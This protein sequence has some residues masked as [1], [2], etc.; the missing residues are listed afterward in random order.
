ME[1]VAGENLDNRLEHLARALPE[2]EVLSIASQMAQLLIYLHGQN[3]PI[4]HRDIKPANIIIR[5]E[6]GAVL[7]DFGAARQAIETKSRAIT[8]IVTEG[9][10]PLEQYDASGNQGPWTDIYALGAVAYACLTG[11]KPAS[12][13]SRV[14]NDSLVPLAI[15]AKHPA[16]KNFAGAIESALSVYENERPQSIAEFIALICGALSLPATSSHADDATRVLNADA[17]R[18]MR[19]VSPT[20]SAPAPQ[21]APIPHSALALQSAPTPQSTKRINPAFLGAA[22]AALLV[23][24]VGGWFA[25]RGVTG[26]QIAVKEPDSSYAPA[27]QLT[28]P[29]P[30]GPPPVA[31]N[32]ASPNVAP[33]SPVPAVPPPPVPA[34]PT[35]RDTATASPP[36]VV[37]PA[38]VPAPSEQP[39]I[40][41]NDSPAAAP[42]AAFRPSFDC[43]KATTDAERIVCSDSQLAALDVKM[44]DLYRRGLGSVTDANVFLGEQ[45]VWLSQRDDCT[46]KQCLVVSYN[47]RIKELERWVGR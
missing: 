14:R 24:A 25:L 47:D 37:P 10:A 31:P 27:G 44:T 41:R 18:V 40:V 46:D 20:P 2:D 5:E 15:A 29:N 38:T 3:P 33:N 8:S 17:T 7:I 13:T 43:A 34:R 16:S 30:A 42:T 9:Y 45:Q 35:Q 28:G 12:A 4:V 11:N 26:S 6:G 21:T 1:F 39:P 22:A 23:I 19:P 36:P 32:P